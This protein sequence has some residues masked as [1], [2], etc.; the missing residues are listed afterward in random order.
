MNTCSLCEAIIPTGSHP[1]WLY[2]WS[3]MPLM[4]DQFGQGEAK[5][6]LFI[7]FSRAT[8]RSHCFVRPQW[9]YFHLTPRLR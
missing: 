5:V 8:I 7:T 1:M 9:R 3:R 2:F 6:T 4:D